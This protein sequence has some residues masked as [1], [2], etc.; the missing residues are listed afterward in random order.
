M[1][2]NDLFTDA[3]I[4]SGI[5]PR[6]KD[7]YY[8][9]M[10]Q[11]VKTVNADPK[12]K[13]ALQVFL[14]DA[15]DKY[16]SAVSYKWASITP[17]KFIQ[18]LSETRKK[19]ISFSD[20]EPP[21]TTKDDAVSFAKQYSKSENV[22]SQVKSYLIGFGKF[23]VSRYHIT[24]YPFGDLKV[25]MVTERRIIV[26]ND[27]MLDDLYN[28]LL[29]GAPEYYSLF[30]RILIE[31]GLRG[32]HIYYLTYGDIQINRPQKDALDR[33]FYP[34]FVRDMLVREKR[35]IKET[36]G[37][38]ELPEAVYISEQLKND[39]VKWCDDNKLIGKGY[40]FKDFFAF[41]SFSLFIR[42]R[43]QMSHT[44]PRLKHKNIKYIPYGVRHTWTS[45][46][47]AVTK[48]AGDLI[49]LGGWSGVTIPLT[50][51][52]NSMKACEALAIAKKWEIYLPPD[53]KDEVLELQGRCE[54]KEGEI[55]PGAPTVS[56]QQFDDLV[57]IVERLE[58]QLAQKIK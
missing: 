23:L 38:K 2:W 22:Q 41:S 21:K 51:Y 53:K 20:L 3:R 54:R 48:D 13:E 47:Y 50:V 39:I 30:F 31:T 12:L 16:K 14:T 32:G 6:V 15:F 35:K 11:A 26:Y 43:R 45:V 42:R 7:D 28:V 8:R 27:E 17:P 46:M 5:H 33:T 4:K 44:A 25:D 52:R 58:K 10:S 24:R 40:V 19:K 18:W 37:K 56:K 29:A 49:D 9:I 57:L 1:S 55:V 34:I 36:I